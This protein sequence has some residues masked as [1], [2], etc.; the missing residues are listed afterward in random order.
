MIKC[1]SLCGVIALKTFRKKSK[2][3]YLMIFKRLDFR[4]ENM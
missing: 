3:E 1:G 4:Y 2:S